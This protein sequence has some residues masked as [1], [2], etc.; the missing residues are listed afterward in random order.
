MSDT[1]FR[2]IIIVTMTEQNHRV[3]HD[4]MSAHQ[5]DAVTTDAHTDRLRRYE[6]MNDGFDLLFLRGVLLNLRGERF[7][8]LTVYYNTDR[9][10][11]SAFAQMWVDMS[12]ISREMF[13]SR[14]ASWL[15]HALKWA[16]QSFFL[17][18]YVTRPHWQVLAWIVVGQIIAY[19]VFAF[20]KSDLHYRLQ[21]LI[22]KRLARHPGIYADAEYYYHE[23]RSII[24]NCRF[25]LN[26]YVAQIAI[27]FAFCVVSPMF[28]A[29]VMFPPPAS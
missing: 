7:T 4:I 1:N 11:L 18:A 9:A 17:W 21:C 23:L 22:D 29:Y 14:M 16:L 15:L 10:A 12:H 24:N 5:E 26:A 13:W 3:L 27:S 28:V 2:K 25:W 20:D 6:A 8:A 19:P